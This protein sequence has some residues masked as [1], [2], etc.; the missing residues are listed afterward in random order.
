[1]NLWM[2][3]KFDSLKDTFTMS[4]ELNEKWTFVQNSNNF[5]NPQKKNAHKKIAKT[6]EKQ[7]QKQKRQE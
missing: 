2:H 4:E 3:Q 7:K 5:F 1:M 6:R